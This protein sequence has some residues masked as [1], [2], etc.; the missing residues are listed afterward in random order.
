MFSEF[1]C[2]CNVATQP[3]QP[4][5]LLCQH[6]RKLGWR[7]QEPHLLHTTYLSLSTSASVGVRVCSDSDM[8]FIIWDSHQQPEV[9]FMLD[10]LTDIAREQHFLFSSSVGTI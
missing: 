7:S 9:K 3:I 6:V 5:H 8:T 10:L 1:D 4:I 2:I